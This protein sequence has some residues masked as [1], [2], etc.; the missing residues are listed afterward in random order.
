M[1]TPKLL[2]ALNI[3]TRD[4]WSSFRKY[5]LIHT[6]E[7]S[8]NFQCFIQLAE[9][10]D[11]LLKE[12]LD[13][14]L[15]KKYFPK[16]KPK[17]FSNLLSR[18]FSWFED[19]F[20]IVNFESKKYSRELALIQGYNQRGLFKLA[21]QAS[22]KLEAKIKNETYL[23]IDQQETLA[24]LYHAQY[25]SSNPIKRKKGNTVFKDC[26]EH[27]IS[28]VSEKSTGYLLDLENFSS[29]RD[30]DYNHVKS[31]LEQLHKLTPQTELKS[32]L[33]LAYKMLKRKD[34]DAFFALK[35]SLEND[36]I[37]NE[38]SNLFLILTIYLRR[39][40]VDL[41]LDDRSLE[42]KTILETHQ[43]SYSA[44]EQ[45]K[46][47]K[48]FPINLFIGV[49][50]LGALLDYDQTEQFI[51][52]WIDKVHTEYKKSVLHYCQAVNAFRH[53]R[54][55][56]MPALLTGLEFEN[57]E[58]KIVSQ[59]LMIIAQ[60]KLDEEDLMMTMIQNLKKQ[61]KRNSPPIPHVL[62]TKITNLLRVIILLSKSNYDNSIVIDLEKYKPI[63]YK[64]WVLKELTK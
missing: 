52:K 61:L 14:S 10:K 22:S 21:N 12:G 3:I 50:T 2:T 20:A 30:T 38:A 62:I 43:L 64:S 9:R 17:S 51:N 4:E 29:I 41:W 42:L 47:Q 40:S 53:K 31:I 46:M 58:F 49:S 16:M 7:D 56:E 33:S 37:I 34:L 8:D 32:I 39:V 44:L 25:Y 60:Y 19:W 24:K 13:E 28:M 59:A 18:L 57:H 5:L 6:R 48:F 27:Y 63:F 45:N 11:N 54:Y 36:N 15:R 26:L 23:D 1:A 35:T 55:E